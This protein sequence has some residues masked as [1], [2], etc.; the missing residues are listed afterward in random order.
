MGQEDV[1]KGNMRRDGVQE[2]EEGSQ[3]QSL[4][5]DVVRG[6]C[7][8]LLRVLAT[9]RFSDFSGDQAVSPVR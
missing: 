8:E 2:D 9:D 6:V 1:Q 5:L 7:V 3:N 4:K